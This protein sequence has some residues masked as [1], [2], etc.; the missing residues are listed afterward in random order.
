[1]LLPLCNNPRKKAVI[2]EMEGEYDRVSEVLFYSVGGI[3]FCTNI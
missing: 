2:L 3:R 1:M